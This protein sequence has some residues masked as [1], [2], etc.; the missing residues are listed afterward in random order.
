MGTNSNPADIGRDVVDDELATIGG[1]N[2]RAENTDETGSRA[3]R[4][5]TILRRGVANV[6]RSVLRGRLPF[7]RERVGNA[8]PTDDGRT[9]VVFRETRANP[10]KRSSGVHPTSWFLVT[11]RLKY[12]SSGEGERQSLSSADRLVPVVMTPYFVGL[13]GFRYKLW[14]HNEETGDFRS[15]YA[16]ER[17]EDARHNVAALRRLMNRI[18]VPG[19]VSFERLSGEEV[20]RYIAA[21]GGES[22]T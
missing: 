5:R 15:L 7:S 4:T 21:L 16:F 9:F 10:P 19:S 22:R 6:A 8:L 3:P 12:G 11:Y 18:A 17:G 14:M 2:P 1:T 20:R 13:P